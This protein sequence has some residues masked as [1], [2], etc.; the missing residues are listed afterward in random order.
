VS[1]QPESKVAT[2]AE[3]LRGERGLAL[4]FVR[5]RRGA[6]RLARKL[7]HQQVDAVALHGDMSQRERAL[8]ALRVR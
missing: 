4:V 7:A 6:D 5:T 2:L 3:L 8:R 1:V